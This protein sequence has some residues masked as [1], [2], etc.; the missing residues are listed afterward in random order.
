MNC[1]L[2]SFGFYYQQYYKLP[3]EIFKSESDNVYLQQLW[4]IYW[5]KTLSA[6]PII[7]ERAYID[8]HI[9]DMSA[10]LNIAESVLGKSLNAV[11]DKKSTTS[12]EMATCCNDASKIGIHS[13]N[14]ILIEVIKDALFNAK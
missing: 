10:K 1:L 3:I 13:M 4:S 2:V 9:A 5:I 8:M 11:P 12:S 7:K 6:S 14:H